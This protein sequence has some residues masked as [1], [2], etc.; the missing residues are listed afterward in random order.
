MTQET[1]P[2]TAR[3]T[4]ADGNP[5]ERLLAD[6]A[7][8]VRFFSRL[9]L[10]RL[11]GFDDPA[12]LPDFTRSA[13]AAPLASLVVALPA[14]LIG[15]GLGLTHL[16]VMATGLLVAAAL[17]IVTGALHEDGLSDLADGFFGGAT[18]ER[19]LEIM[20][21]S[22]IGAFGALALIGAFGLRATLIAGLIDRLGPL[23]AMTVLLGVE[24]ASRA[25][26]VWQWSRLP[27]ARPG[28]LGARFGTPS[29]RASLTA[30]TLGAA[31]LAPAAFL[32]PAANLALG[33]LLAVAAVH[34]LGRLAIGK[35]GGQTGDVLGA[36]QQ[37]GLLAMLIGCLVLP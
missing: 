8:C 4:S 15:L 24:A 32:V 9:P 1:D 35:I 25:L 27:P 36:V 17:S 19:R 12:A 33:L 11:G 22:R 7:A 29:I 23:A 10:P 26:M 18:P 14:A 5:A 34:G 6:T 21:D 16:P 20:K 13:R 30:I 28:G 2:D 31:C 37:L 3:P